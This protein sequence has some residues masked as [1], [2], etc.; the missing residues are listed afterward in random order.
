MVPLVLVTCFLLLQEIRVHCT[1][2]NHR[3]LSVHYKPQ[4]RSLHFSFNKSNLFKH[5]Q[6]QLVSSLMLWL[7]SCALPHPQMSPKDPLP[8]PQANVLPVY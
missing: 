8:T 1:P 6:S 4:E 3:A 5:V 2:C 7:S